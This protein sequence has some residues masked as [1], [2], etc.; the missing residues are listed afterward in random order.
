MSYRDRLQVLGLESLE[1]RCL[2]YDLILVYKIL[3]GLIDINFSLQLSTLEVTVSNLSNHTAH[4]TSI[5]ISLLI[6]SFSPKK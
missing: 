3:H 6:V 5:S 2:N 4:V 1:R